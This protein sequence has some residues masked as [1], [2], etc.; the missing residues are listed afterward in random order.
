MPE[1]AEHR[2][3]ST[4]LLANVVEVTLKRAFTSGKGGAG[5]AAHPPIIKLNPNMVEIL[6]GRHFGTR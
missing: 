6:G 4:P 1:S 2:E 3:G 5:R